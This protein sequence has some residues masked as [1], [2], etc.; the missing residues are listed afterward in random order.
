M[1][2]SAGAA[3]NFLAPLNSL[4]VNAFKTVQEIDVQG[5]FNVTKACLPYLLESTKRHS[6][7]GPSGRIIF[8]S[9]TNHYTGIPL[10]SHVNVA[11]AGVDALS[12]SIAI[13][14]GPL[15]ITSNVIAPGPIGDTEGFSRLVK[16]WSPG[17]QPWKSLPLGRWGVVKD[18]ADAT[19][20]L[21]SDAANYV[22]GEVLVVDGAS[23][24]VGYGPGRDYPYPD[25]VM[26][27]SDIS[28][29]VGRSRQHRASK[30]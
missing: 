27:D 20:F 12:A 23:W 28:S 24:R 10:Q 17:Q 26:P 21:F 9:A 22:N 2:F 8:V 18:I 1:A 15:G 6:A 29:T 19:V 7:S 25:S 16:G 4:S 13:E 11:K 30:I 3:G 5:S 14:Y